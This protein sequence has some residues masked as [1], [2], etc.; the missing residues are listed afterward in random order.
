MLRCLTV[1]DVEGAS[2]S[3]NSLFPAR[4]K[5]KEGHQKDKLRKE[6]LWNSTIYQVMLK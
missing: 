4:L 6:M 3:V 1:V 2:I 5:R